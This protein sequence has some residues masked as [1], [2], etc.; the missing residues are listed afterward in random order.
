MNKINYFLMDITC[1]AGKHFNDVDKLK[2]C[3]KNGCARCDKKL[4]G[5]TVFT[6]PPMHTPRKD[7]FEGIIWLKK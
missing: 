4:K 6:D 7:P 1:K 5:D 3:S 2:E